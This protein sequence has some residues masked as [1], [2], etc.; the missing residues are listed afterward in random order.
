[1]TLKLHTSKLHTWKLHIYKHHILKLHVKAEIRKLHQENSH[2]FDIHRTLTLRWT[3]SIWGSPPLGT[4]T[5]YVPQIPS[6]PVSGGIVAMLKWAHFQLHQLIRRSTTVQG[7]AS[8]PEPSVQSDRSTRSPGHSYYTQYDWHHI[9]TRRDT[10]RPPLPRYHHLYCLPTPTVIPHTSSFPHTHETS[11]GVSYASGLTTQRASY[12]S[13]ATKTPSSTALRAG[14]LNWTLSPFSLISRPGIGH[15]SYQH[16][17]AHEA[18]KAPTPS[19]AHKAPKVP[20]LPRRPS[21]LGLH[22]LPR[23]HSLQQLPS[24]PGLHRLH[25]LPNHYLI[26]LAPPM[27]SH[28]TLTTIQISNSR[29]FYLS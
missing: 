16:H 10:W 8:T 19:K 18:A 15:R 22:R 27:T 29:R 14:I 7:S 3:F 9:V 5:R 13:P 24:R 21:I 6:G 17:K 4:Y 20:W 25:K 12:P 28:C 26:T 11:S 23:L 1:M 2:T